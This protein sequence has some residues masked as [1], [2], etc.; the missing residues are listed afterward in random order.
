MSEPTEKIPA[1]KGDPEQKHPQQRIVDP[2]DLVY[3]SSYDEEGGSISNDPREI[4]N[5]PAV[6]PQMLDSTPENL[7][8]DFLH[9]NPAG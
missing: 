3:V 9:D 4:I 1:E 5:N 2:R 8:D 6:A 7:R